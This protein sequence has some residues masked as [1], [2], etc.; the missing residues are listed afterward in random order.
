MTK[1]GDLKLLEL[2]M[3]QKPHFLLKDLDKDNG[4]SFVILDSKVP[5][6]WSMLPITSDLGETSKIRGYMDGDDLSVHYTTN[7]KVRVTGSHVFNKDGN[8]I[9]TIEFY[10]TSFEISAITKF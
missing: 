3:N 7:S 10:E 1:S 4:I 2:T 5:T 9:L 6:L 8:W